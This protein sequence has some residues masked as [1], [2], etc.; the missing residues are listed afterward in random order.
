MNSKKYFENI[1]ECDF[2]SVLGVFL[3]MINRTIYILRNTEVY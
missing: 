2:K 1:L 3:T